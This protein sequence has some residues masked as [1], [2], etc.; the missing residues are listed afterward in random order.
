MNNFA[1]GSSHTL[2][3]AIDI[4]KESFLE[5]KDIEHERIYSEVHVILKNQQTCRTA[6]TGRTAWSVV[7]RL[8]HTIRNL[9]NTRCA[10]APQPQDN[11]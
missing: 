1:N 4:A 8:A 5:L 6:E 2:Q 7:G 11:T 9:G 3:H 10:R